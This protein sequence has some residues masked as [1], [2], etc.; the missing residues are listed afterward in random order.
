MIFGILVLG[1][2]VLTLYGSTG[3]IS[4]AQQYCDQRDDLEL[5]G[6]MEWVIQHK[7]E[8]CVCMK[9]GTKGMLRQ[10]KIRQIV[11][12]MNA[13]LDDG[14]VYVRPGLFFRRME[15][16]A[17]D[18]FERIS[19]LCFIDKRE[20]GIPVDRPILTNGGHGAASW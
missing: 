9:A 14:G 6:Y 18:L 1:D 12:R 10:L 15:R 2:I 5:S 8:A 11:Q 16:E 4:A 7:L 3:M 17:P 19:S 13:A 20:K